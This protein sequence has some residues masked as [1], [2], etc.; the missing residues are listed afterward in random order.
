MPVLISMAFA[1]IIWSLY[2]LAATEALKTM[3]SLEL[4]VVTTAVS[5]VA[6]ALFSGIYLLAKSKTKEFV[7]FQKKLGAKEYFI[8]LMCGLTNIL[9]NGLFFLALTLSHKGGVS[10]LYESWPLIAVIATPFIIKKQWKSVSLKEVIISL[11]SLI[12][13]GII[14]LSNDE[15]DLGALFVSNYNVEKDFIGLMGYIAAFVGAYAC[16]MNVV[17][18]GLV[19][20]YFGGTKNSLGSSLISALYSR[21]VGVVFLLMIF[22]FYQGS[23]DFSVTAIFPVLFIGIGV[24][25]AGTVFYNY[26]F[27]NTGRPTIHILYYFVPLF[28]VI[29][30]WAAGETTVNAG[31]FIGGGIII[32]CNLYLYFAGRKATVLK[33]TN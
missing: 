27:I 8:I 13:V 1:V 18:V 6:V 2:P 15:I 29:A 30:L 19:S 24:M 26:A 25:I 7:E 14:I 21:I 23:Y 28:A 33:V 4:I 12:G 3:T 11:V 5:T 32:A 10:L 17:L 9:C 22:F 20:E 31:L 16:A